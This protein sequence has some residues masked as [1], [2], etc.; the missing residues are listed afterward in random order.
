MADF[1]DK[2]LTPEEEEELDILEL[3]DQDG[4]KVVFEILDVVPYND[5]DYIVVVPYV[6]EVPDEPESV[7]IYRIVPDDTSDME[8]YVGLDSQEEIDAV[9]DEF[10]KRNAEWFDFED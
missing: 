7:E 4:N 6:E 9:Y 5:M 1:E 2:N 10:Q 3:E 8:T